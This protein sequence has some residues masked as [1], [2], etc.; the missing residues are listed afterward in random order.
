METRAAEGGEALGQSLPLLAQGTVPWHSH[1]LGLTGLLLGAKPLPALS[2]PA[3][4]GVRG[5]GR[6]EF[7]SESQQGGCRG[8]G[9]S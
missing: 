4:A 9:G 7:Q 5:G 3:P 8:R 1:G 6:L 2:L